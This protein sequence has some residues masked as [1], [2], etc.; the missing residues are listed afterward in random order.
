[1]HALAQPGT[2]RPVAGAAGA[3]PDL[4]PVMGAV[5]LTLLDFETSVWCDAEGEAAATIRAW[6]RF[7]TGVKLTN[8]PA[9]ADFALITRTGALPDP[10]GFR[11]GTDI[12]PDRSTTMLLPVEAF[13]RG[14]QLTLSG[15]GIDGQRTLALSGLPTTLPALWPAN[16]AL[17]PRGVDVILAGPDA[18]VGLP[19]TTVIKEA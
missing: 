8:D 2:V 1:M 13:G 6:L 15:P 19:R 9:E 18:V 17:F 7:H 4:G 10:A 12:Y 5:A 11:Q 14:T 16:R 3:P